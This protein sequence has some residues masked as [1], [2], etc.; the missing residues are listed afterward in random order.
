MVRLRM[1]AH[2]STKS[3]NLQKMYTKIQKQLKSIY[4]SIHSESKIHGRYDNIC[5]IPR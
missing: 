5:T 3:K 2:S 4:A 1:R